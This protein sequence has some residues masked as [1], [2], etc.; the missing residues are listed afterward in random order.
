MPESPRY[1]DPRTLNKI[2][3]LEL[4]ARTVVEG[5]LSGLHRSPYHGFSVEF[6]E[7]REY[8]PGDELR[9]LDW[10]VYGKTDRFYVKQYEEET[11]L[12]AVFAVDTSRSMDYRSDPDGMSKRDYAATVAASLA[13]LIL[14]QRD[15]AG[16]VLF[17]REVSEELP[18]HSNPSHL[19]TMV[20]ALEDAER[21]PSTDVGKILHDLAERLP[22]RGLVVLLSDLFDDPQ[23]TLAGLR[24]L[25]HREHEVILF[26]VL[27]P[28]ETAFPFDSLT[29]FEGLEVAPP[30][31]AD[32]RAL[33]KAYLSEMESFLT[34][35][36]EGCLANQVDYV[37]LTTDKPLDVALATYLATRAARRVR[38]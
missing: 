14:H 2:A 33:R 3:S 30:L 18:S 35:V 38:A 27:D 17:D 20:S 11:N 22:R 12:K 21:R 32:P 34:T 13:Y 4:R 28:H 31:L 15:A 19:H 6:A 10:K 23:R 26:H 8:A 36:R 29:L 1:L 24:H 9:H 7:H 5:F 25:R 16:L 37:P